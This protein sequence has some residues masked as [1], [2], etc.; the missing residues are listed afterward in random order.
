MSLAVTFR[1]KSS[2]GCCPRNRRSP[3]SRSPACPR[4]L[5]ECR[6]KSRV[7]CR[8][9]RSA[10]VRPRSMRPSNDMAVPDTVAADGTQ[11]VR[12][13]DRPRKGWFRLLLFGPVALFLV[14]L[15]AFALGLEG[16]PKLVPS[17]LIGKLVPDLSLPP[18]KGRSL[19]LAAADLKGQVSLVNVFASW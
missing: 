7:G 13:P 12:E 8:F 1:S 5:Q 10:R 4:A 19:G 3:A 18:V 17:P 16:D 14:L 2:T 15:V 9:T 6:V 11:A